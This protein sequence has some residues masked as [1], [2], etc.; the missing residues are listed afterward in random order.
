MAGGDGDGDA[1]S[2]L[3]VSFPHRTTRA[4]RSRPSV[5][6]STTAEPPP[7]GILSIDEAIDQ[8]ARGG[9]AKAAAEK[10]TLR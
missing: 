9:S 6:R 1:M 2:I 10:F 5:A 8:H 4:M 7:H 3:T